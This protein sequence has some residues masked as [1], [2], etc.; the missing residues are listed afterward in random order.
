MKSKLAELETSKNDV[1]RLK[2]EV[3]LRESEIENKS[4]ENDILTVKSI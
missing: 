2:E 4:R 1:I 3:D